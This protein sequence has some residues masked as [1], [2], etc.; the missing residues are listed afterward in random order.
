MHPNASGQR[1]LKGTLLCRHEAKWGGSSGG[2]D[3][4]GTDIQ[5]GANCNLFVVSLSNRAIYE[6]FCRR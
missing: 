3:D 2:P 5:T 6:I 4:V 1:F